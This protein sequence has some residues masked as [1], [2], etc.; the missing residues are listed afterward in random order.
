M[1]THSGNFGLY[2]SLKMF[3]IQQV[4]GGGLTDKLGS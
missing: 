4:H 2:G 1:H 3:D